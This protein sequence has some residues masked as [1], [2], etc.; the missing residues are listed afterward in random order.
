VELVH[1]MQQILMDQVVYIIPFYAQVVEAH[2]AD[3]FAGWSDA[4]A[5]LGLEDPSQ[6]S[7]LRPT[8]A[9]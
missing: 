7:I 1:Q 8:K 3:T 5:P 2:R 6:L 9:Q 4:L